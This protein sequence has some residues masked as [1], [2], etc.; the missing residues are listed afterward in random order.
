MPGT[1]VRSLNLEEEVNPLVN[2]EG[3]LPVSEPPVAE[4]EGHSENEP[5]VKESDPV[6]E[7]SLH[8]VH[9][10][11]RRRLTSTQSQRIE[12]LPELSLTRRN[13]IEFQEGTRQRV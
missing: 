12:R 10:Q 11:L 2:D 3:D 6:T 5:K 9:D 1:T 7:K 4:N 8:I 13:G